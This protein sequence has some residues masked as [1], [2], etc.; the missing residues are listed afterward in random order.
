MSEECSEP[1]CANPVSEKRIEGG[2]TQCVPCESAYARIA[3]F[4]RDC[5]PSES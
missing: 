5:E 3:D 4:E 2:H 1:G